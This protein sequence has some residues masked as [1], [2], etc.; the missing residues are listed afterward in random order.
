M[1]SGVLFTGN[2]NR[3]IFALFQSHMSFDDLNGFNNFLDK[4]FSMLIILSETNGSLF[5]GRKFFLSFDNFLIQNS[6]NFAQNWDYVNVV[7]FTKFSETFVD[8]N[9]RISAIKNLQN[10]F[11]PFEDGIKIC[12]VFFC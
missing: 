2:K 6:I 7:L 10:D 1:F 4:V 3:N 5:V 12:Y 9:F 11:G 8:A